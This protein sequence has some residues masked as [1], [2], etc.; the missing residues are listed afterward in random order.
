MNTTIA[1]IAGLLDGQLVRGDASTTLTG[2]AALDDATSRQ[3]SFY[4]NE[5]FIKQL[6]NT[7]AAAILVQGDLVEELPSPES[8][9]IIK[10][11]DAAA[12]FDKIVAEFG[13]K[14]PE[15]VSGVA[16]G[17]YVDLLCNCDPSKI[18]VQPGAVVLKHATIG[19]G[20]LIQAG[21]VI[22][23]SV[24]IGKDCS[25][26]ANVT[27]R[28]N[29]IIGDRVIIHGNTTIGA[30]G[31]GYEFENGAHRKVD[32]MGIV[33]IDSDVEI[34]ASTT[35]DRARFGETVIGEGTK[36]DNQVQIGHNAI[37]GK[38]CV[39]VAQ[40]GISGSAKLGNYVT[41]GARVGIA[42]HIEI[43]DQTTVGGK[44]GVISSITEPGG[45][46]F[47]YPAKP[48]KETLRTNSQIKKLG[49]LLNR[50]SELEKKL[51]ALDVSEN[52]S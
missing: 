16:E 15:F 46:Y 9:A 23:E 7:K 17:A 25:I 35:I 14:A 24:T 18:S 11:N 40:C 37:L 10:V 2:F 44:S 42:G 4:V 27:I 45:T 8:V 1:D 5:K 33:R 26:G 34:G 3:L 30:D 49:R 28:E 19:E 48:M 51:E 13:F 6:K 50:V 12:A 41:L 39:I 47:G 21:A 20:T 36:I 32:Q 43:A 52:S 31:F 29:C 22:G 38:H